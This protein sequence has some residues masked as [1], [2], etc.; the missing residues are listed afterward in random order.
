MAT[1]SGLQPVNEAAKGRESFIDAEHKMDDLLKERKDFLIS[2]DLKFA[3]EQLRLQG[4][5]HIRSVSGRYS[6][7]FMRNLINSIWAI[8]A[9]LADIPHGPGQ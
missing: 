3:R 8:D 4:I 7:E 5:Q 1:D 9:I 2:R 6:T